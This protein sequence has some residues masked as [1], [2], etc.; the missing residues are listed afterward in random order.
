MTPTEKQLA[1]AD[2]L[3]STDK[4]G[5]PEMTAFKREARWRQHRWAV[6]EGQINAFG[7][8]L[9]RRTAPDGKCEEIPNG[10][11]LLHADAQAGRNFHPEH[12]SRCRGEGE[13]EAEERDA[14]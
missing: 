3:F 1:D 11:K 13:G 12:P 8:H 2:C 6:T 4:V 9:G 10:T 14:R 7:T 5:G